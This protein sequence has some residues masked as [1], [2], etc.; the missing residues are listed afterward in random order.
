MVVDERFNGGGQAA[1]YVI[2][3]LTLP[4]NS[5]WVREGE[6]LPARRSA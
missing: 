3:Y 4:L 1:D 6:D 2:D 5:Y